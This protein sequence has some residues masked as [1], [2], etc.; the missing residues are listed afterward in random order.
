MGRRPIMVAGFCLIPILAATNVSATPLY[1]AD[2][3]SHLLRVDVATAQVEEVFDAGVQFTDIAF[4][5]TGQLYGVTAAY[6]YEIDPTTGWSTL[7]GSHGFGGPNSSY[8]I[9]SL[10]FG[11]NG[12]LYAAGN[13]ILISIDTMTGAGTKIGSLSGHRSAGDLATDS[14]GRLLMTTDLGGIVEINTD[15]G[16]AATLGYLPYNDVYALATDANG[17]LYGLRS[18]NQILQI[19]PDKGLVVGLGTLHASRLIGRAWGASFPVVRLPEPATV[20][21]LILGTSVASLAR[22]KKLTAA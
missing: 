4:G 5:S 2:S 16:G 3:A 15:R 20:L 21:L 6:L 1:L 19:D 11:S 18:T 9:D 7:I 10:A 17:T 13:N 22:R 8:G 12:V 14:K